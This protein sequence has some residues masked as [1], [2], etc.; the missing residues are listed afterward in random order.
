MPDTLAL[1]SVLF[2]WLVAMGA[3]L[4]SYRTGA[5]Q[6]RHEERLSR[7]RRGWE[8]KSEGLF[9]LI[10]TC[11]SLTDAIDRPGS[12]DTME[13]LDLE[14][15][16]YQATTQEH[17]GVSEVGVRVGDVVQRLNEL[18]PVVEV[19]GS[20]ACR[21]AFQD[22]RQVLRDSG[23]DPRASDRLVA[24]RR[25]KA[26]AIEAKDYRSAATARRLEREVLEDARTRLTIDLDE[27]RA[28]AEQLITAARESLTGSE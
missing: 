23:Y 9:D 1:L 15:G 3:L 16:D 21:E 14:R 11:R 10:A 12:I 7:D 17:I 25:G 22:L 20:T 4:I 2:S 26:A 13:A 19:Y 27:T 18:V 24:V 28:K 5:E 8:R 6:R